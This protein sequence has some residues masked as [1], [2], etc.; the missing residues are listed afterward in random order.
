MK[1]MEKWREKEV[2]RDEVREK[3]S[4]GKMIEKCKVLI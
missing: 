1:K 2:G 4:K 3:E